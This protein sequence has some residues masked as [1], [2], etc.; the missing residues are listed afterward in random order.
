MR[1]VL[2]SIAVMA[3]CLA[4]ASAQAM[5]R[6]GLNDPGRSEVEKVAAK[7]NKDTGRRDSRVL[8][9][10]PRATYLKEGL[11]LVEVVRLLGKPASVSERSDGERRIET[12]VFAL[13]EGRILIAEFENDVLLGSRTEIRQDVAQEKEPG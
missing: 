5:I 7:R 8:R 9:L 4:A 2:S 10:G 12:Y 6:E 1:K 3:L 13:S 11:S